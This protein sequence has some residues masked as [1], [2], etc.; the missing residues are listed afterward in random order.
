[1]IVLDPGFY[2]ELDDVVRAETKGHGMLE[3]LALKDVEEKE[4]KIE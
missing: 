1:M 4:E 3:V 2:R